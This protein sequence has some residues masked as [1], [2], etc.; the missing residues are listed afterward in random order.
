MSSPTFL[1]DA[2]SV[3]LRSARRT[4]LLQREYV[5]SAASAA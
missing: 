4:A 2:I 5:R 1:R 3:L